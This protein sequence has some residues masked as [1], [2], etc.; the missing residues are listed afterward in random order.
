MIGVSLLI[1]A[2]T[3]LLGLAVRRAWGAETRITGTATIVD[4]DTIDLGPIRIRLHGIDAPEAGQRCGKANGGTWPCG[5][6]AISRLAELVEG[7]KIECD[8]D[9]RDVYGR[10]IAVCYADGSDVNATLVREGQAWAFVSFSDDYAGL[11]AEAKAAGRGVWQGEAQT[12]W[13][14]RADKWKRAAEASPRPGCPI[15][16]N[17]SADGEHIYH[18]PWSPWYDKTKIDE[19]KGERWF[20]DEAEAQ[21]AGWRSAKWR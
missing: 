4:G 12:P 2:A 21:V 8:A 7:K 20:C 15:K 9:D 11:E 1:V 17:I 10:I 19:A 5:D 3:A 13:D 14:Y 6:E 18:T 16:G